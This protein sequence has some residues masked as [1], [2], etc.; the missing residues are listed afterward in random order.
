MEEGKVRL[1]Y[2]EANTFPDTIPCV[3]G[4]TSASAWADLVRSTLPEGIDRRAL[5]SMPKDIN[6]SSKLGL[7]IKPGGI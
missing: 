1:S 4:R 5:C 2:C 7:G 3:W 6:Q